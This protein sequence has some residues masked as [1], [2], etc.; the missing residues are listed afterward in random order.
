MFKKSKFN[1][2]LIKKVML[3]VIF[4]VKQIFVKEEV[5][6]NQKMILNLN[7]KIIFK[8]K[9]INILQTTILKSMINQ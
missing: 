3:K 4:R 8:M 2:R 1:N 5:I 6:R 7:M 9:E